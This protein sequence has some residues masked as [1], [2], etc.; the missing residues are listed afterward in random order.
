MNEIIF[1]EEPGAS[2]APSFHMPLIPLIGAGLLVALAATVAVTAR[3]SGRGA[4]R[5]AVSIAV[6]Q[7]SIRFV[8]EADGSL[9]VVDVPTGQVA[10]R[11]ES[12]NNGFI[13]GMLRG[14][15]HKRH[16]AHIDSLVPYAL[17][18][19]RDGQVTLDDPTTG[20]HVAINSFGPTQIASFEQLFGR[21]PA[22]K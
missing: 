15:A 14:A 6:D 20:M 19:W 21:P 11:L 8:P 7:R 5:E 1:E 9:S 16:V 13:F 12:K 10:I 18:R 3:Y 2:G 22:V 4:S 17:T